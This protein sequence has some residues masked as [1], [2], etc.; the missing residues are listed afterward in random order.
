M[1]EI[2]MISLN[3]TRMK[4]ST[5]LF[6]GVGV[7]RKRM[8]QRTPGELLESLIIKQGGGMEELTGALSEDGVLKE[9]V[10]VG[11]PVFPGDLLAFFLGAAVVRDRDFIDSA[12]L[13]GG[14]NG[15]FRFEAETV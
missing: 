12:F 2:T 3:A 10:Q 11:H 15:H 13:P 1:S 8:I 6:A 4:P 9:E 7:C 14:F 5:N